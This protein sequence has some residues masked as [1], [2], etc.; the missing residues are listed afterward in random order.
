MSPHINLLAAWIG[1]T[2]GFAA[3]AVQGLF[4]HSEAWLGGYGAWPRR[5]TRLGHVSFFG[6]A[7]INLAYVLSVRA[8]AI[9]SPS[10]WPPG[11]FVAG[12]A[13]MPLVCYLAAWR[14]PLRHLFPLPVICLLAGS[15]LFLFREVLP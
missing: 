10:P 8:L 12:A 4:F 2:L 13:L 3:G 7:F 14:K 11:L 9:P 6:L 5:M 15:L 1:I